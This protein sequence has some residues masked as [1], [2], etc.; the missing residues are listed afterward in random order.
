MYGAYVEEMT[1]EEW[2][3]CLLFAWTNAIMEEQDAQGSW[4]R[5]LGDIGIGA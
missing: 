4:L 5:G 2:W 3:W 1:Q